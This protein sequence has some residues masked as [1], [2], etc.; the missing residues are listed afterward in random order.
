MV[1]DPATY[2]R[3]GNRTALWNKLMWLTLV[4]SLNGKEE[5]EELTT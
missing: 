5:V 2:V 3:T 4:A 1:A